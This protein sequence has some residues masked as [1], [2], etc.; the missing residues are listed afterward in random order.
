MITKTILTT[1][2]GVKS[3]TDKS[4]G[5]LEVKLNDSVLELY[6][7]DIHGIKEDLDSIKGDTKRN[8]SE[9]EN[10]S[11]LVQN[12][13]INIGEVRTQAQEADFAS[14]EQIRKLRKYDSLIPLTYFCTID[15]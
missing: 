3:E 13:Q 10:V 1:I 14:K 15:F 12:V 9:L 8:E 2:D 6:N 11:S 5:E 4:I 7:K